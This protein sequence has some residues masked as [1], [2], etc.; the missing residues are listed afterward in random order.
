MKATDIDI[1]TDIVSD[2]VIDTVL[3]LTLK[4]KLK[5]FLYKGRRAQGFTFAPLPL[6]GDYYV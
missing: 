4:K 5:L 3:I 6:Q 2:I 1:D